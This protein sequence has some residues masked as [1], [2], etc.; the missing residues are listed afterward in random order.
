[1]T[2]YGGKQAGHTD[3][4]LRYKRLPWDFCA[5]TLQPFVTPYCDE[6]GNLFDLEAII[7][8]IKKFKKNP[9]TGKPLEGKDL[10]KLNFHKNA[11]GHFHCPVLFKN[12]TKQSHIAAVRTTGNVFSM[13]AIEQLNIKTKNW[14]D[15]LTSDPFER[16]D[17]IVLQ[18]PKDIT[19][20]NIA[21]FDHIVKNLKLVEDSEKDNATLKNINN[22]ARAILEELG[23]KYKEPENVVEVK[24]TPDQFNAVSK[25][26]NKQKTC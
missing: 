22:E 13:E 10:I 19:K 5:L 2:L 7:A 11:E 18:D 17:I 3:D 9:V 25:L 8:Y 26:Q 23:E 4:G 24:K 12:F 20:F 6:S 1:M 16:K 14:T 15:L 21:K